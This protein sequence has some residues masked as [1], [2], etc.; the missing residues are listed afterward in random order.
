MGK[1]VGVLGRLAFIDINESVC[2]YS[3]LHIFSLG[4]LE[5]WCSGNRGHSMKSFCLI[6]ESDH[7]SQ[8]LL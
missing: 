5:A 6:I 2:W 7:N 1:H 3:S 4:G 8:K